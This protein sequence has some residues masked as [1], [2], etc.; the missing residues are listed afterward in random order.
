MVSWFEIDQLGTFL[1][2]LSLFVNIQDPYTDAIG[3]FNNEQLT[4]RRNARTVVDADIIDQQGSGNGA[5]SA[6]DENK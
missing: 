4:R 1:E 2:L 6:A 5:N 3:Q